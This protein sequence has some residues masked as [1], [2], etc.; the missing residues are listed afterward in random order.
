MERR[1]Y[2]SNNYTSTRRIKKTDRIFIYLA[3]LDG[4]DD[5]KPKHKVQN[6]DLIENFPTYKPNEVTSRSK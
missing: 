1:D 5:S 3:P 6:R 2:W 4:G